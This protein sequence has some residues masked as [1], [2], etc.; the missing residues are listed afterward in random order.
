MR[1]RLAAVA[2]GI[3][4]AD[5]EHV[6]SQLAL[7]INDAMVTGLVEVPADPGDELVDAAMKLLP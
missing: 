3:G 7:L 5:P 1:R 6:A 2:A 4:V